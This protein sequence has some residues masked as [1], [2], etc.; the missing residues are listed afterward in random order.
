[1]TRIKFMPLNLVIIFIVKLLV[2]IIYI[3][4]E[5]ATLSYERKLNF[6]IDTKEIL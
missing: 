3:G 6:L 2:S 5:D 4:V 1:M